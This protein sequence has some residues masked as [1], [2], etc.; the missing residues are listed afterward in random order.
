MANIAEG[1]TQRVATIGGNLR[2]LRQGR[3]WNQGQLAERLGVGQP[4]VSRIERDVV[5][6]PEYEL[7]LRYAK[8]LGATMAQVLEGTGITYPVVSADTSDSAPTQHTKPSPKSYDETAKDAATSAD[9]LGAHNSAHHDQAGGSPVDE[10]RDQYLHL[11]G[12]MPA[13]MRKDFVTAVDQLYLKMRTR[14]RQ[15]KTHPKRRRPAS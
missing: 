15:E 4:A 2:R 8:E 9:S 11:Y 12:A 1:Y 14:R 5:A 6:R 13:E 7:V 10:L 3:G